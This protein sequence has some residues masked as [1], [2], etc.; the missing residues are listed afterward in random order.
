[1]NTER[2]SSLRWRE[3]IALIF[4]ENRNRKNLDSLAAELH[5]VIKLL[6]LGMG[7][8]IVAE[9]LLLTGEIS[10]LQVFSHAIPFG[11]DDGYG[12]GYGL[13]IR[14]EFAE[15]V[16]QKV[17]FVETVEQILRLFAE[18][19]ENE[20]SVALAEPLLHFHLEV[21]GAGGGTLDENAGV[22]ESPDRPALATMRYGERETERIDRC[23][24]GRHA[25]F[26]QRLPGVAEVIE[27]I[28]GIVVVQREA[29]PQVVVN[30]AA[31]QR[32]KITGFTVPRAP[33]IP[34]CRTASR[35]SKGCRSA[36]NNSAP[37]A[38]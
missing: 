19:H 16:E 29:E 24:G 10:P 21:L 9:F 6:E 1:V 14:A 28:L 11:E 25:T 22:I 4:A 8:E 27:R 2:L 26:L 35:S 18:V 7:S 36:L 30:P 34:I 37:V 13:A 32:G 17:Y 31:V 23:R 15:A 38:G 5:L 3:I 33:W 20:Q 12:D